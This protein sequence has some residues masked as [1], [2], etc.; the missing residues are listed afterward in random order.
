MPATV[1]RTLA[2]IYAS[3]LHGWIHYYPHFADKQ[4]KAKGGKM[5]GKWSWD[6]HP[7][8]SV[9]EPPTQSQLCSL[10]YGQ[11]VS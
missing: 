1:G 4:T 3:Q 8:L 6:P 9:L 2:V 5:T 11:F 7:T 10:P